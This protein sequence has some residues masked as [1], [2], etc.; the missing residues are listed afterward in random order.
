MSFDFTKSYTVKDLIDVFELPLF[1]KRDGWSKGFV[2]RIDGVKDNE[3]YGVSYNF[4]KLESLHR[5]YNVNTRF[6]VCVEH[7]K[8]NF[9]KNDAPDTT[10]VYPQ[11]PLQEKNINSVEV[12]QV[13]KKKD[14]PPS[15]EYTLEK[16]LNLIPNKSKLFVIDGDE[17]NECIYLGI[18]KKD[19]IYIKAD[20]SGVK[21]TFPYPNDHLAFSDDDLKHKLRKI[22]AAKRIKDINEGRIKPEI[23]KPDIK[24]K[25][26]KFD[27]DKNSKYFYL[28]KLWE[29]PDEPTCMQCRF[30]I[31]GE[32]FPKKEICS[33]FVK[34]FELSNADKKRWENNESGYSRYC[35]DSYE[36]DVFDQE[37]WKK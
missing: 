2:Y 36:P 29:K 4:A 27:M 17:I 22:E 18:E 11:F 3:T 20:V 24:V 37:R 34:V 13:P 21:Q 1:V 7:R 33:D 15:I 31:S 25:P 9:K 6:Y 30:A 12:V 10:Q 16:S 19:Q 5:K 32:C 14:P 35:D 28:D 26:E 23:I 8:V